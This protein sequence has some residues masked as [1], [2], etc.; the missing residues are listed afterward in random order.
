MITVCPE[1]GLIFHLPLLCFAS[2]LLN[3]TG[4]RQ[5]NCVEN[6]FIKAA[7]VKWDCNVEWQCNFGVAVA[8]RQATR[9]G[10]CL[11]VLP[12]SRLTLAEGRKRGPLS[13]PAG[14]FDIPCMEN[15]GRRR[16]LGNEPGTFSL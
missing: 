14:S 12:V 13:D 1:E 8:R 4:V 2:I 3:V 5:K 16:F 7:I 6:E 9:K 15:A 11:H 10:S